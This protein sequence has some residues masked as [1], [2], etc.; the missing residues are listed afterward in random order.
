VR[1]QQL[2][3]DLG[4]AYRLR[5][6]MGREVHIIVRAVVA[7]AGSSGGTVFDRSRYDGSPA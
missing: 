3:A 5:C 2:T 7:T 6:I 4:A 1:F